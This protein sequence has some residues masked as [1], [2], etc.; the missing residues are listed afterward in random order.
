MQE[1][2]QIKTT[3]TKVP[4][5]L[6]QVSTFNEDNSSA[7]SIATSITA[8]KVEK[9]KG[10]DIFKYSLEHSEKVTT[11]PMKTSLKT[12]SESDHFCF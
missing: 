2:H 8:N 11:L 7:G 10:K 5:Y 4:R 12:S 9:M 3:L 6:K 1:F